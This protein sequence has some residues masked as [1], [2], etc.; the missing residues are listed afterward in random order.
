MMFA[1][2]PPAA[3]PSAAPVRTIVRPPLPP[4][5]QAAQGDSTEALLAAPPPPAD[6]G[7]LFPNAP[8]PHV[9]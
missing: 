5:P 3:L 6:G 7:S 9:D 4:A 1:A 2:V 8:L